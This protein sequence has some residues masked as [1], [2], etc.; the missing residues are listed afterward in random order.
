MKDLS[1]SLTSRWKTLDTYPKF[2]Q[3]KILRLL[4][5]YCGESQNFIYCSLYFYQT[6]T[7]FHNMKIKKRILSYPPTLT[8]AHSL[9]LKTQPQR[10]KTDPSRTLFLIKSFPQLS[11]W[12][13]FHLPLQKPQTFPFDYPTQNRNRAIVWK[14]KA[15]KLKTRKG[16][17]SMTN[18]TMEKKND[19][20]KLFPRRPIGIY[21]IHVLPG[22]IWDPL[23]MG[24]DPVA[25]ICIASTC[26]WSK[27]LN[28]W[29]WSF[30]INLK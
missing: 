23:E 20:R 3:R 10:P 29:I 16:W 21:D 27:S 13:T 2:L 26:L 17:G 7:Q 25:Y 11:I 30:T 12:F 18:F 24:T 19:S 28:F 15:R 4:T 9:I 6:S 8:S 1:T 5:W 14:I 22:W